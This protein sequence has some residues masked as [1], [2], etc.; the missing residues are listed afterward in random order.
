MACLPEEAG[1]HIGPYKLLERIGEGGFGVVWMAEQ[2]KPIRRRVALKIIKLG[3]DTKDVVARFEQERQALALM[4]HL[5][6]ARVFDAGAR[7][8]ATLLSSWNWCEESNYRLLRS[9]AIAHRRAAQAL[10]AGLP[11]RATRA[12]ER[13]HPPR[14]QAVQCAGHHAR[15]SA[16]AEGHRLRYSQG[17]TTAATHRS[18]L[19]TH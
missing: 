9:G 18:D 1:E 2:E 13:D 17:D 10:H 5:N 11:R 4:D 6:I 15:W 8:W 3:M 16:R 19:F 14:P 12:P 7:N